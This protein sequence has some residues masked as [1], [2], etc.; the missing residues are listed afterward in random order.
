MKHYYIG[1]EFL[2]LTPWS[3]PKVTYAV[4]LVTNSYQYV[5]VLQELETSFQQDK[6][7]LE[8]LHDKKVFS[9]I[10]IIDRLKTRMVL[11]VK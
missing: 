3:L 11:I 7:H 4:H 10:T 9:P 8:N 5:I 1:G 2:R 6:I